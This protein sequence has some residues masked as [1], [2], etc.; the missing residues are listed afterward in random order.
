MNMLDNTP[1]QLSRFKT[2]IWVKIIGDSYGKYGTGSQIR[3][4]NSML[5]SSL[6][7]YSDAYILSKRNVTVPNTT[8]AGADP[9]NRNKKSNI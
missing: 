7:D 4:K 5:R 3:F 6:C 8:A 9:D 2:K 1:N